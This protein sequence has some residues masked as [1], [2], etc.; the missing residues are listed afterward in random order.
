MRSAFLFLAASLLPACHP[1]P[2]PTRSSTMPAVPPATPTA[3]AAD[4]TEAQVGKQLV[5]RLYE[6]Y[7][8]AGRLDQL[9]EVVAADFLGPAGRGPQ[10]F[11]ASI[12]A[13]RAAFPDLRYTLEDVIGDG[14]LVAVRFTVRGTHR[15]AFRSFAATGQPMASSGFALFRVAGGKLVQAWIETDR[16]GFLQQLGAIPYDPAFGPAR[17]PAA[18]PR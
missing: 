15:H 4:I 2:L 14:A 8:N 12:G 6:D 3:P 17:A 13:L 10:G 1:A 5:R 7:L 16:L 11:A 18:T 9:D